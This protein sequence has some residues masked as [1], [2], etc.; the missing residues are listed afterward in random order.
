[1]Y[2]HQGIVECVSCLT[3]IY[4]FAASSKLR[5]ERHPR[6]SQGCIYKAYGTAHK[7]LFENNTHACTRIEGTVPKLLYMKLSYPIAIAWGF[8]VLRQ[9]MSKALFLRVGEEEAIAKRAPD[10]HSPRTLA[11]IHF[12]PYLSGNAGLSG[13]IRRCLHETAASRNTGRHTYGRPSRSLRC[14]N[15]SDS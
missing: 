6:P 7:F 10:Q 13:S 12:G 11:F 2:Q 14:Y 9:E 8:H 3:K 5:D 15:E 4:K 1:M